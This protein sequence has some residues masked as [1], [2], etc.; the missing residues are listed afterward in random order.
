LEVKVSNNTTS[1]KSLPDTYFYV[2]GEWKV[3]QYDVRIKISKPVFETTA[4]SD[5]TVLF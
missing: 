2:T 3:W 1:N 4:A 5:F